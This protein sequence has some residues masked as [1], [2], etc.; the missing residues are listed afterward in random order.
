MGQWDRRGGGKEACLSIRPV[1]VLLGTH[2][3]FFQGRS[4]VLGNRER[5]NEAGAR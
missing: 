3:S 5:E 2:V 4:R 1:H